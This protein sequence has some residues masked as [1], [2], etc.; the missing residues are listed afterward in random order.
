MIPLSP[1]PFLAYHLGFR[2]P[3]K[4]RPARVTLILCKKSARDAATPGR[5]TTRRVP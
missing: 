5:V 1:L 4:R 2:E 3:P